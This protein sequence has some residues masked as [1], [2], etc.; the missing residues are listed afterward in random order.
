KNPK[1]NMEGELGYLMTDS[2]QV[3]KK[4]V[5][6]DPASLTDPKEA[7]QYV[8][9][10]GVHRFAPAVGNMHGIAA[11]RPKLD[12]KR[13]KKIRALLPAR[14]AIV[15]HG[16][17]GNSPIAFKKA[18]QAGISNI[19]ISTQLR[20]A[21]THALKDAIRQNPQET[22]PYKLSEKSLDAVR[23]KAEQYIKIFGSVNKV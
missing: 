23:K 11:N 7:A 2:S 1:I 6:I 21:D 3:Y 8:K 4:K 17:S 20:L 5:F 9:I 13:I 22:T 19:H 15:L 18:I 12:Y 16:G 14:V 10:T